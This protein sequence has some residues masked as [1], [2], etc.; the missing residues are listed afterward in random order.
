MAKTFEDLNGNKVRLPISNYDIQ[1][2][3]DE[4]IVTGEVSAYSVII[5][6]DV[7][8]SIDKAT[9]EAIKVHLSK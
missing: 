3:C 4:D 5:E 7:E 9:Y 8:Y 2:N 1:L 6:G